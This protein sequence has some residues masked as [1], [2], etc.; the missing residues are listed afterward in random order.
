MKE[1][2]GDLA[3]TGRIAGAGFPRPSFFLSG[4]PIIGDWGAIK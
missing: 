4:S 3:P 2:K 1:G